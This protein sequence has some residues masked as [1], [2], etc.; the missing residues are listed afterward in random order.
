M[1]RDTVVQVDLNS[2]SENV[3]KICKMIGSQVAVMAVIKANGY[4]H[5]SI[6]IAPS[7]MKSG[8]KYLAVATLTE[9]LELRKAYKDF[10]LFILG[11]TPNRLL[12]YVVENNITQTIFS[13]EQAE[14]LANEGL[15]A[16]KKPKVHLKVDTGFHRLGIDDIG[17]LKKICSYREKIE[18][19][20]IFSHLAL[21]NDE[22]NEI[23]FNK[24]L[25]IVNIL[26]EDGFYFKYKHISDSISAV[27]YPEYRLNMVRPGALIFGLKGSHKKD[28]DVKQA[29]KFVTRISQLHKISAG[30]GVGYDYLWK[31]KKDTIIGTLPFGYADGYPRNMRGKGYVSIKGVKCPIIGV[32][33]MDQCM[34]DLSEV[35]DAKEGDLAVI[36]GDGSDNTMDINEAS[37][38]SGTNKNEIV[39][40]ITARPP[41]EYIK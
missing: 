25:N 41:R 36:Y 30:E 29:I 34:V 4:G 35:P 38:L 21:V 1:L 6:D 18:I 23:Q 19:E 33:C 37:I 8:A 7:I 22:E 27:D 10:P 9:A 39:A 31:A 17:E 13:V 26:E 32:I 12:K 3:D 20:G 11:H 14:I 40:R 28:I 5:G 15:G 24:F 2:I 16:C